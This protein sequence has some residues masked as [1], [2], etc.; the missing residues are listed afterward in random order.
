M[1]EAEHRRVAKR[2]AWA[3]PVGAVVEH[4]E[5]A[6]HDDETAADHEVLLAGGER[7]VAVLHPGVGLL[8]RSPAVTVAG[9]AAGIA[10]AE[11][12]RAEQRAA[13]EQTRVGGQG[14]AQGEAGLDVG[15]LPIDAFAVDVAIAQVDTTQAKIDVAGVDTGGPGAETE[16]AAEARRFKGVSGVAVLTDYGREYRQ[17]PGVAGS[18]HRYCSHCRCSWRWGPGW[19]KNIL[20]P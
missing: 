12:M 4:V 7:P 14:I 8:D 16:L 2:C 6:V 1:T 9:V 5:V 19:R 10:V 13:C 11:G 17:R 3:E 15:L 18:G 20:D